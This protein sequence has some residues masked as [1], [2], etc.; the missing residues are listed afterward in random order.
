MDLYLGITPSRYQR[1]IVDV[2]YWNLVNHVQGKYL[3]CCSV[4]P[5][6]ILILISYPYFSAHL[7]TTLFLGYPKNSFQVIQMLAFLLSFISKEW[8]T[9]ELLEIP[10]C[11]VAWVLYFIWPPYTYICVFLP[12][13][14]IFKNDSLEL[15]LS[16]FCSPL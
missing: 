13:A 7:W 12:K 11:S 15:L 10:I 2:R 16:I 5:A 9:S 6:H 8:Q 3:T 1:P 14:K 4:A